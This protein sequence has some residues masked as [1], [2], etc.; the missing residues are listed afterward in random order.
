MTVRRTLPD[1]RRTLIGAWCFAD[2]YG[3]VA[4]DGGMRVDGHPHTGLQTATWLFTGEVEHRDT[5]GTHALVRPR[6]LNLMTAG[7]GIAHS[8]YSTPGTTVLHG[9]QLWI[10][11]PDAHRYTAPGFEHHA[12]EPVTEQ[13]ATVLVFLGELLGAR[14]PARTY[15]PLLGAEIGLP[16]GRTLRLDLDP[17]FEHGVLVDAG[18]VSVDGTVGESGQL[19]YL[20]AGPSGL[21]LAAS[22]QDARALLLGGAPLGEPLLMW[23]NFVGRSHDDIA[24]FRQAWEAQRAGVP[25]TPFGDFPEQWRRTLPAPALPNSRLIP[26]R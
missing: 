26:R 6:E 3:P 17:T 13:G 1:R 24:G 18:P 25:G 20:P 10:A 7:A 16:A 5:V 22:G 8:E 19:V 12:P 11:L 21:T 15:S 4:P 2:H 9:V 23:W 14:S